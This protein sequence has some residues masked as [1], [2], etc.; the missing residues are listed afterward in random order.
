MKT[1]MPFILAAVFC[2]AALG[3]TRLL[4]ADIGQLQRDFEKPPDDAR[5]MVR[6]WWFGP[7]V[8]KPGLEREMKIMKESGIGGFE[9][10]PTYPL[11]LDGELPGLKKRHRLSYRDDRKQRAPGT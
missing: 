7:A 2:V 5:I 1:H 8:T 9:V 4:A 6:W 11:A 3:S 10:Q